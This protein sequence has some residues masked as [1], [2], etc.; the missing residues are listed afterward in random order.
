MN[1]FSCVSSGVAE[2]NKFY[3]YKSDESVYIWKALY[4]DME[5]SM[6]YG[7]WLRNNTRYEN[8]RIEMIAGVRMGYMKI[9]LHIHLMKD[10]KRKKETWNHHFSHEQLKS[11]EKLHHARH[12]TLTYPTTHP[13][14]YTHQ[15]DECLC[16]Y[17]NSSKQLWWKECIIRWMLQKTTL[18][19]FGY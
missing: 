8:R 14:T 5:R 16:C 4:S 7:R 11:S 19:N 9:D 6:C 17:D 18:I 13:Y 10:R 3:V 15:S 2:F 12:E 1:R